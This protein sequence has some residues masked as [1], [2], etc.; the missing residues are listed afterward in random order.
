MSSKRRKPSRWTRPPR[1]RDREAPGFKSRAPDVCPVSGHRALL[2][3]DIVHRPAAAEAVVA[4]MWF[5][6]QSSE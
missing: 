2:L 4:S 6:G 5:E 1:F 3:Q